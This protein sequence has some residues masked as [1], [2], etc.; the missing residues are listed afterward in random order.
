LLTDGREDGPRGVV[1]GETGLA[2]A[3]SVIDH[4]GRDFFVRLCEEMRGEQN[5]GLK[6]IP[7]SSVKSRSDVSLTLQAPHIFCGQPMRTRVRGKQP[8]GR[9]DSQTARSEKDPLESEGRVL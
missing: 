2:H 1:S 9:P 3:R 7:K 6:R 4:E 8:A 5:T